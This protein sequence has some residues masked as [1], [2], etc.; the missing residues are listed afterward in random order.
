RIQGSLIGTANLL[1][2]LP[3]PADR[4]SQPPMPRREDIPL[5]ATRT[6]WGPGRRVPLPGQIAGL[7]P[8]LR[9]EAGPLG[10]HQPEWEPE[11]P[12]SA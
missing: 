12:Q 4:A 6:A 8:V 1:W 9:V 7:A 11:P 2:L 3:A 10:R 5:T